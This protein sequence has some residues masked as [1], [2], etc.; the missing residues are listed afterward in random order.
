MSKFSDLLIFLDFFGTKPGFYVNGCKSYRS[1]FGAIISIFV[2][3][4]IFVFFCIFL[5]QIVKHN[6]P[7]IVHNEYIDDDSLC[8]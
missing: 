5:N 7:N 8:F 4:I 3:S 6:K 1:I 2:C